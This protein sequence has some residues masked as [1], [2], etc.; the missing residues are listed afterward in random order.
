MTRQA[1]PIPMVWILVAWIC[2][3]LRILFLPS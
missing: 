3:I 1:S 2:R